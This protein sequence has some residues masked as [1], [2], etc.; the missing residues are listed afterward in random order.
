MADF[1]SLILSSM[2]SMHQTILQFLTYLLD[3]LG[4]VVSW[5]LRFPSKLLVSLL[6]PRKR[7]IPLENLRTYVLY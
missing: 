7:Q 3:S 6:H 2:P 1:G 4:I 5:F